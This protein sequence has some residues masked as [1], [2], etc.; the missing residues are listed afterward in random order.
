MKLYERRRVRGMLFPSLIGSSKTKML[1][2]PASC[3]S[4]VSIPH[5]K[6]KNHQAILLKWAIEYIVS[7]P[8]RKFKN[9]RKRYNED[10]STLFPS[11]IGSSKT[12]LNVSLLQCI[13]SCFHPS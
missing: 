11:L 1:L 5:R 7:I 2:Y 13:V 8:H 12:E 6:F 4:S 9:R 10:N 3:A